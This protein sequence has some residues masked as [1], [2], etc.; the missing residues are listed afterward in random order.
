MAIYIMSELYY[1]LPP[2]RHLMMEASA[3]AKMTTDRWECSNSVEA[4]RN[5]VYFN[6]S[7]SDMERYELVESVVHGPFIGA[8]GRPVEA[9]T[10]AYHYRQT[11]PDDSMSAGHGAGRG[12]KDDNHICALLRQSDNSPVALLDL[13]GFSLPDKMG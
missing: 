1:Y 9:L 4:L 10:I 2:S 12:T 11:A 13:H 5:A 6:N 7:S 8:G 3:S